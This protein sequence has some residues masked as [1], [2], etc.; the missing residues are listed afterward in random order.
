VVLAVEAVS[1]AVPASAAAA[2]EEEEAASGS[3]IRELSI[4]R[5][6]MKIQSAT[7]K[8]WLGGLAALILCALQTH[9]QGFGGFF[10]GGGNQNRGASS[11][12]TATTYN[13]AGNVGNATIMVDPD[14]HNLIINAD[15]ETTKAMMEVIKNLDHPQPQVLI[16][17]VFLEVTHNDSLD[18]GI[19][20]SYN[21]QSSM[22]GRIGSYL[23]NYNIFTNQTI[24]SAG[25]V[26]TTT[27]S[28]SILPSNLTGLTNAYAINNA[29]GLAN[30]G[31]GANGAGLYSILGADFTAT[32][33]AIAQ[34]G[35]AQ[36]LS[37]P[38]IL[39]RNN[40]PA[41]IQIGQNVPLITAVR[42]DT[43]GNA[44]NS[45][46]YQAVGIILK[47]TP[48]IT[49]DGLVQMIVQP[50]TSSI[51]PSISIPISAGVSAP[52]IDVRSADTVVVT[53]DGQTV[54]IGGLMRND[55]GEV[56]TKI[57]ILGDIPLLGNLFKHKVSSSQK[58]ELL[59]FL[60]PHV[61]GAPSQLA[62][63]A[64]TEKNHMLIP[65]SYSEQ[66][67]DRFLDKVPE[68]KLDGVKPGKSK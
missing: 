8:K 55:S 7:W 48:F 30:Q 5:Q 27:T 38:S 19:E 41:T 43:F 49:S 58:T 29:F 53:P 56:V 36:L 13:P 46:S 4:K 1:A 2:A 12:A 37:R 21:G 47:V 32:L 50:S 60:T 59:I 16:K 52:V 18:I 14:T 28:T 64:A 65:K 67:L 42:Y 15:E 9:A 33:R 51:D 68:K 17:V 6:S 57:P 25:N 63:L 26:A 10:G 23:T 61:I 31:A 62:A 66:E 40:Q 24:T 39:A 54:V 35:K 34:A 20:G 3:N 22:F 44:I 11:T 45:V